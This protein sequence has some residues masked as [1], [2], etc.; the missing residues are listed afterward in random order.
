MRT[1]W[2]FEPE[3]QRRIAHETLEIFAPL[4]NRLGVWQVKWE[5]EDLSLRYLEPQQYKQ[6]SELV[7]S[8]R[9][10]REQYVHEVTQILRENLQD[11]FP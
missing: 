8:K 1:L 10:A 6:I 4:A 9:E 11:Y 2:A 5:L 7:A 3:K